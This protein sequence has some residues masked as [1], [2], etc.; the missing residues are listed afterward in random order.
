MR[1]VMPF[2]ALRRGVQR[3]Q[4][5]VLISIKSM[6]RTTEKGVSCITEDDLEGCFGQLIDKPS[7]DLISLIKSNVETAA[8]AAALVF[9]HSAFEN[10]V[11]DLIKRLVNYDPEP[12][13]QFIAKK[14][15][16]FE[17]LRATSADE[18]QDVLLDEWL[19]YAERAPFPWKVDKVFAVLQPKSTEDVIPGFH[20]DRD[21][22]EQIDQ[23]R[24]SLTHRP[25]FATPIPSIRDKLSC[26]HNVVLLLEKLA[27]Q[28]YPGPPGWQHE[29]NHST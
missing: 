4:L 9:L 6:L 14:A 21:Q 17:R 10:A 24:H 29:A 22:F 7:S 27:E 16:P 12:W 25:D 8:D 20:F 19:K 11:F 3:P 1:D 23:L 18:V 26:L 5:H 2:S 13:L 15:V 28:K